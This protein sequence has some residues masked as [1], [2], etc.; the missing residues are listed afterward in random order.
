MTGIF[1]VSLDFE[2]HW[3]VFDKRDRESRML[4]YNNTLRSIPKMLSLFEEYSVHTTWAT[5]GSL[6][7]GNE[8]E[9]KS[10]KPAIEPEYANA[11]YSPYLWIKKHGLYPEKY[12]AHFAPDAIEK[13]L[14]S[15]GQELG[16]HTFSH[17][18]CL[19]TVKQP[20]AF[21]E[22]LKAANQAAL[23]FK[24][25]TT[26]LIFPR[27]QYNAQALKVCY[28][29]GIKVVRSNP[30]AGFWSPVNDK[31]ANL[32]RKVL[33]TGDAYVKLGAGRTSYPLTAIKI[34]KNEPL[35]LPASR[36][37]RP[38]HPAQRYANKLKLRRV[39]NE[40]QSA[41]KQQ[42]VYHLWWHPENFG[43]YPQENLDNLKILL[44][45]YKRCVNRYGME[46]WNM[47]EYEQQLA[48]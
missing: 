23:K 33:R 6:F 5:V 26:S 38:W 12:N 48:H 30:S 34:N 14:Q 25:K 18:Y 35:Q 7:A 17:Y 15:A 1:T 22:D 16:T 41:A 29:N 31:G 10:F 28:D 40:M 21:A 42:E 4:C 8:E 46:S 2:L 47:G 37:L 13:I 32:L 44:D 20:E 36:F 27:N 11:C 19:E 43:D 9:W 24:T 39:I 3:G 45:Q